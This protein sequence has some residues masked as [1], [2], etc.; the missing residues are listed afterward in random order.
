LPTPD[1]LNRITQVLANASQRELLILLRA[2]R[3]LR[4]TAQRNSSRPDPPPDES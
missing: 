1:E 3:L 4:E 2:A